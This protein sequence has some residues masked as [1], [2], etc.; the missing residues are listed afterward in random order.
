[1]GVDLSEAQ[2]GE[3]VAIFDRL[4]LEPQNLTAIEDVAGAVDRHLA[5]SLAGLTCPQVS[6][7]VLADLGSGGGFPGLVIAVV[8]PEVSVV[9]VE[10]ERRKSEWLTRASADLPNVRVVADRSEALA[11]RERESFATVTARAVAPLVPTME[12]AAPLVALGG[13]LVAWTTDVSSRDAGVAEAATLLGFD[14]PTVHRV[15]PFPDARRAI[16]TLRKSAP[17][18][19]R[20]PR[21]AGRASSRPL[22]PSSGGA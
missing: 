5:D 17:T 21:R 7:P 1:M 13:H 14:A 8:R 4:L 16:V 20:F 11:A 3:L 6:G 22:V 9:L 18:P 10:S 15:Q 12:L 2:A 19:P